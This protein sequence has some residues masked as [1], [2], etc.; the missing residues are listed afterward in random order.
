MYLGV[1]CLWVCQAHH[2]FEENPLWMLCD[3]KIQDF[4]LCN[5]TTFARFFIM[6]LSWV[7]IILSLHII[8]DSMYGGFLYL[9]LVVVSYLWFVPHIDPF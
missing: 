2:M 6:H 1:F 4:D 3:W 8:F 9:G 7:L 5:P